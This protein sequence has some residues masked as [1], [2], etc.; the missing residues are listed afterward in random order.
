[1]R[2][3]LRAARGTLRATRG[4]RAPHRCEPVT[5]HRAARAGLWPGPAGLQDYLWLCARH[6]EWRGAHAVL[7]EALEAGSVAVGP[8]HWHA[9]MSGAV[10]AGD[11]DGAER[12][13]DHTPL[14]IC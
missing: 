11:M 14:S 13:L 3:P 5:R 1:M 7:T 4:T 10:R 2:P 12:M 8:R 9:V 6:G